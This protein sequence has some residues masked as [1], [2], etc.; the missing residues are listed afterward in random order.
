MV[1]E[2]SA[3]AG[4]IYDSF[5]KPGCDAEWAR[6]ELVGMWEPVWNHDLRKEVD[7]A[8]LEQ[9]KARL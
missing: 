3:R 2:A 4:R 8:I 7:D 9:N 1:L 6:Q 5:G